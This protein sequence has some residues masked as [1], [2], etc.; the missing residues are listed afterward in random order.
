MVGLAAWGGRRGRWWGRARG[1]RPRDDD[2]V[3]V[4]V[5]RRRR[6]HDRGRSGVG[7][8]VVAGAPGVHGRRL[9]SAVSPATGLVVLYR[10]ALTVSEV[11]PRE[12][13]A[14]RRREP[15][16]DPRR[17]ASAS[18][19]TSTVS[20]GPVR[21]RAMS[22]GSTWRRTRSPTS[23]TSTVGRAEASDAGP[24]RGP[25]VAGNRSGTAGSG[26]TL[27]EGAVRSRSSRDR[28]PAPANGPLGRSSCT[29]MSAGRGPSPS[30]GC[31][32]MASTAAAARPV[33]AVCDAEGAGRPCD[34]L[35]SVAAV[36]SS[37]GACTGGTAVPR[38][39]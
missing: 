27:G 6:G 36:R 22:S 13:A 25:R 31:G 38:S 23:G 29:A 26:A 17:A 39:V 5:H 7:D 19:T 37:V 33:V 16:D 24:G 35:G 21:P 30:P 3:D 8:V 32:P 15:S 11:W 20:C 4:H 18:V 12:P 34:A 2:P 10:A 1:R 9:P 28:R 14:L